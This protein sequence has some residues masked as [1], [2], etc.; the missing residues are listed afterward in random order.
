MTWQAVKQYFHGFA[1]GHVRVA[2][3]PHYESE[4]KCKAFHVKISFVCKRMK[5]HFDNKNFGRNL[6]FIMRFKATRKWPI[7]YTV[8]SLCLSKCSKCGHSS[9]SSLLVLLCDKVI[10]HL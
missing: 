10:L 4:A 8:R 6:A 1:I 5:T 9:I 2:F 7:V 3:E